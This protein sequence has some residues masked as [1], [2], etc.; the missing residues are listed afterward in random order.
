MLNGFIQFLVDP[1]TINAQTFQVP[2]PSSIALWG[3]GT[4]ILASGS[5]SRRREKR[6]LAGR[7]TRQ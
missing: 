1:A 7:R 3:I 2:E 4:G 6:S 5:A